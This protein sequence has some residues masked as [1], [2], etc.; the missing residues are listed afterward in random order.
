MPRT[1]MW[2]ALVLLL[3]TGYSA[4][5]LKAEDNVRKLMSEDS[6]IQSAA[7]KKIAAERKEMIEQLLKI[8]KQKQQSFSPDG[9]M[10]RALRILGILRAAEAVDDLLGVVDYRP[11]IVDD[12]VGFPAAYALIEIGKPASL[13]ALARLRKETDPLRRRL[14]VEVIK[15]VEG[16]DAAV[17]LIETELKK[18]GNPR[19]ALNLK[20]ALKQLKTGKRH[21]LIGPFF[22]HYKPS[23]KR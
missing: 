17:F 14:L 2:F 1:H 20:S 19:S 12:E 7:E 5:G 16:K 13:K 22:D 23:W 6:G 18:T 15:G 3:L 11:L 21:E 9:A 10:H 4:R 8:V